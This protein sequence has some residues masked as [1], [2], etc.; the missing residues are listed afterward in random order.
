[1]RL[2]P[3]F[4]PVF[5]LLAVAFL[6]LLGAAA[7]VGLLS[8]PQG[9]RMR[10]NARLKPYEANSF[11]ADG[12]TVRH[13]PAGTVAHR[14]RVDDAAFYYG[15]TDLPPVSPLTMP[16]PLGAGQPPAAQPAKAAPLNRASSGAT[17]V[18]QF[19]IRVD[20]QAL[21]EGRQRFNIYCAPCHGRA[22]DGNG[23][24]TKHGF[25]NP[26]S[27]HQQRLRQAPVGYFFD[28]ITHGYGLM[29]S[30]RARLSPAQRWKVIAYIRALQL[31]QYAPRNALSPG[32]TRHL[33]EAKP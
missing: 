29:Y 26:P 3:Y 2:K 20:R 22:G 13:P 21:L 14:S 25:T 31:S 28:V 19:P 8:I 10:Q 30:Y 18:D 1:M 12:S 15:R 6:G 33:K 11:F 7:L 9:P 32:D 4:H 17:Y 24:I 23:V 5:R 27:F 16:S